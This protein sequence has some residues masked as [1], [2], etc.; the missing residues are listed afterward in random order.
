MI[1]FDKFSFINGKIQLR[2][3]S[4]NPEQLLNMI[5]KKDIKVIEIERENLY[6]VCLVINSKD[7]KDVK[8]ICEEINSEVNV[9][10]MGRIIKF[11]HNFKVYFTLSIGL[12]ISIGMIIFLSMFIWK[13][14]IKGDSHVSPYEIR[15][16]IKNLGVHKGMLKFKIDTDKLENEI[17]ASN[18]NLLWSKV[19]VQGST[20]QIEVIESFKPPVID[21][22]LSLGDIVADKDGEIVRVYTQSGT[23]MVKAGDIVKKGDLLIG[24]YQ[25]KEGNV[26]EVAPVG[27]VIAKT[28]MEFEEII[29][30]EGTKNVNTKNMR[31]EYYINIFGKKLYFK[32]YKDEFENYEKINCDGKLVKKNI[33]YEVE[34]VSYTLSPDNVKKNLVDHYSKYVKQNLKQSDSIV[35]VIVK[36]EIVDN[37]LKFKISF[38][39]EE[40]IGVKVGKTQDNSEFQKTYDETQNTEDT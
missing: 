29:E 33:Y 30:L 6:S 31:D 38:V 3:I 37:K 16:V 21:V 11:I 34:K 26:F 35:G 23:A 8:K 10:K 22:D 17:V 4:K 40:K 2:I 20:L 18:A 19:R 27:D 28:F 7:F 15:Q 9:V 36:D 12:G 25:G 39:I 32:K 1:N 14:D 24:G 13:I 5:W